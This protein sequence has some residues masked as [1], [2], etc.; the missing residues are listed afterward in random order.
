MSNN[1]VDLPEMPHNVVN[2]GDFRFER[3]KTGYHGVTFGGACAHKNL[4]M[5]DNGH[6]CTCKDCGKQVS[7]FWALEMILQEY[8][9][10]Y[11]KLRNRM[12]VQ[13]KIETK[14]LRLKA[15][16]NIESAWRRRGT[17][18]TCPHCSRGIFPSDNFGVVGKALELEAREKE[19]PKPY[20]GLASA[21]VVRIAELGDG[22]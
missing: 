12:N 5:D 1:D 11:D 17:V 20:L 21:E 8:R 14:T 10:Q 4:T 15:A 9:R 3:D 18:P 16:Q 6:T 22:N 13:R 2:I 19:P 7:A